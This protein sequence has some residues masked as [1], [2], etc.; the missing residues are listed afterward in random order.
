MGWLAFAVLYLAIMAVAIKQIRDN[1]RRGIQFDWSKGL[2]TAG[3]AVLVTALAI[4]ALFGATAL[5]KPHLG[6]ALLVVVLVIGLIGLVVAVNH[7]WPRAKG[8]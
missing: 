3:G 6:L 4:G 5:G 8:R 7:R 2:A 1:R